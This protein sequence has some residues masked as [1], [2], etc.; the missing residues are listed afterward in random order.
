MPKYTPFITCINGWRL[1]AS[2]LNPYAEKGKNPEYVEFCEHPFPLLRRISRLVYEQRDR[3]PR[4]GWPGCP[5]PKK[6]KEVLQTLAANA[7]GVESI[8]V[9]QW[10]S[11][12]DNVMGDLL[13]A[14]ARFGAL[15]RLDA[16]AVPLFSPRLC[17]T[18][19][20]PEAG[21]EVADGSATSSTDDY[22]LQEG[23]DADSGKDFCDFDY[24]LQDDDD[25]ERLVFAGPPRLKEARVLVV[26]RNRKYPSTPRRTLRALAACPHLETLELRSALPA[27]A[28]N[29]FAD[30][31][32]G[33]PERLRDLAVRLLG[34]AGVAGVARLGQLT[35]LR[36]DLEHVKSAHGLLHRLLMPLAAM[37]NLRLLEVDA[38]VDLGKRRVW[39]VDLDGLATVLGPMGALREIKLGPVAVVGWTIDEASGALLNRVAHL[40]AVDIY[41]ER[42]VADGVPTL[43]AR[44][45][46]EGRRCG[47][48]S[49]ENLGVG[50]EELTNFMREAVTKA[51]VERMMRHLGR[52]L[53]PVATTEGDRADF[54]D[55]RKVKRTPVEVIA[56]RHRAAALEV[57][58][59]TGEGDGL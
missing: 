25:V 18:G 45:Q 56:G 50:R 35:H 4:S 58:A 29:M 37:H 5:W 14:L 59:A 28:V 22:D 3:K 31:C 48:E 12:G 1:Y 9:A 38:E 51:E 30:R 33:S 52:D 32:P 44:E 16:A 57:W 40:E 6:P 7:P 49:R 20:R 19:G 23:L 46:A 21:W 42:T 2:E 34:P 55:W 27:A 53:E 43:K 10:Y 24:G 26:K 8:H 36:L 11:A 47:G 41:N 15:T 54:G 39:T 17:R 13:A